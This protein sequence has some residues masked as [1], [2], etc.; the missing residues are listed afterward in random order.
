MDNVSNEN[1]KLIKKETK[2]VETSV[3]IEVRCSG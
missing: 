2:L 1:S 3:R